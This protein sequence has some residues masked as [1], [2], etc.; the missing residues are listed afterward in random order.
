MCRTPIADDT[1]P[2]AL[3]LALIEGRQKGK[4]GPPHPED[5]LIMIDL[6]TVEP[7]PFL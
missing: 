5:W 4:E 1:Q 3:A 2:R 7:N 6:S